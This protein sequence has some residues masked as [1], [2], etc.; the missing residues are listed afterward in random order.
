M[1]HLSPSESWA[2]VREAVV[3]RLAVVTG[4][5]PDIF[6]VNHVVD[7]GTV[8]FRTARGTKLSAALEN[9]AVAFEVDGYDAVNGDAWS[10]VV[11]G[12]AE[13]VKEMYDVLEVIELPIFPWHAAPEAEVHADRRR[14]H[15][16]SPVPRRG[17]SQ[18]V[19]LGL[20]GHHGRGLDRSR[21][22]RATSK[23]AVRRPGCRGG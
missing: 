21:L 15:H 22:S 20:D 6:P 1:V 18:G 2:L 13:E 16:R 4:G 23:R 10:V 11:K 5:G 17:W 7:H 19:R 9:P 8:V 12:R 3:G 14:H